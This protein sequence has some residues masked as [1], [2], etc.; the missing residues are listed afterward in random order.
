MTVQN[1]G[2]LTF[3]Q[4]NEKTDYLKLAYLQAL[5]LKATNKVSKYA[6]AVDSFTES[7]ITD[8]QRRVFDYV[9]P[10]PNGD[11]AKNHKWK[12]H[13]E[14]KAL[15]VTPY[16]ETIKI[17]SDI[18]FTSS[19]DHWWE[20][21]SIKDICFT[22]H[23]VDY[24]GK[25]S[26]TRNYRKIFD[27]NRLPDI[28]AGFYYFKKNSESEELFNYAEAISKNW[29]Y[30]KNYLLNGT[31]NEPLSTDLVFSLAVKLFGVE[32]ATL[33]GTVPSFVHMKNSV[34]GFS[35]NIPWN[36]MLYSEFD[37]S[38]V[39]I[40]FYRQHLPFHYQLKSFAKPEIITHYEKLCFT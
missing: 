35:E 9:I 23:V 40:G 32:K 2:F 24:T 17:E 3:V 6:I 22:D 10:I 11:D 31:E 30:V 33:P 18:L 12:M 27:D 5:S 4:N 28:Y 25:R 15:T 13:N 21:L 26:T 36:E 39:T 19:I 20:I 8:R 38:N 29:P 37:E 34:Q 16:D 7:L 1:R 14:W